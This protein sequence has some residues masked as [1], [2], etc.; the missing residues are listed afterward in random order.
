MNL[1]DEYNSVIMSYLL[2]TSDLPDTLKRTDLSRVVFCLEIKRVYRQKD[3]VYG[4]IANGLL[5]GA[6]RE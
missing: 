6:R 5:T 2:V 4:K 1:T 3:G